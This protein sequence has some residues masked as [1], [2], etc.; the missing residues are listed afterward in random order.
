MKEFEINNIQLKIQTSNLDEDGKISNYIIEQIEALGKKYSR[1]NKC[2]ANLKLMKN[3][4]KMNCLVEVK[5]FVPGQSLIA[6]DNQQ[7]FKLASK[8]VFDDLKK[9]LVRFKEKISE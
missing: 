6:I 5:L 9:Q 8:M 3:D 4:K 1:I 2:E 7:T